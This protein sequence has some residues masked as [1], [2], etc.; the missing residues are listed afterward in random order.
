MARSTI[1]PRGC[2]VGYGEG[3]A[4]VTADAS[5]GRSAPGHAWD[6]R[7]APRIPRR[8]P[9]RWP[10][11]GGVV[12]AR[13]SSLQDV[14]RLHRSLVLRA[15]RDEGPLPRI[16]LARRLDLSP[17]TITKVVAQ[18]ITDGVIAEGT[19]VA[20]GQKLGR[21]STDV[22]IVPGAASVVGVQVRAGAVN[23]GLCDLLGHTIRTA[24]IVFD[25]QSAPSDRVLDLVATQVR[26]IVRP[27][28]SQPSG[29]VIGVGV[30]APG[31]VDLANRTNVL[32][33]NLGWRDVRFS[34][35]I[36]EATG[37]PTVVDHNVRAMA[38]AE[39]V[40]GR[41]HDADPLLFVYIRT[42]VGAGAVIDGRPF[43]PGPYGVTELGHLQVVEKGRPCTCGATG[44]LETVASEP[45]L[46]Q[47][48]ELIGR[49]AERPLPALLAAV[50]EGE[51][52]AQAVL[53]DLVDHLATGLAS[54][55][56][57][58]NP[59]LIAFGGMFDDAPDRI[60][61]LLQARLVGRVFPVLRDTVRLQRSSLGE[62]AGVIG[63]ASVALDRFFYS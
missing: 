41:H 14:R 62:D 32:A 35:R 55:V 6:G 59:R 46:Q 17:T 51:P 1:G 45:Y 5:L 16:E 53:D 9:R 11:V 48:L 40:L 12:A 19:T 37:L 44:C 23:V 27:R 20:N 36:E 29:P 34:D 7:P 49:A 52:R 21:P 22:A 30:A 57:L 39:A 47:Q 56:N 58:L 18:L 13:R 2:P 60:L 10:G 26:K 42:G 38:F 54:A 50:D 63:A 24:E 4:E 8:G 31:P 15:L 25:P 3:A 43:R 28:R 61:E 33:I